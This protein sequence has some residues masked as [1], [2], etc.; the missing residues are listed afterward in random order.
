MKIKT[1]GCREIYGQI[2]RID[3][4]F[5]NLE[6]HLTDFAYEADFLYSNDFDNLD[7]AAEEAEKFDKILI[8][9][10]LDIPEHILGTLD[11]PK[12]KRDLSRADALTSISYTTQKQVKKYLD[13]NSEVIYNPVQKVFLIN[14]LYEKGKKLKFLN[15]S[16]R[17]DPN[18]RYNITAELMQKYFSPDQLVNVG[19]DPFYIGKFAG[20][21]DAKYLPAFYSHCDYALIG[22]RFGGIELQIPE[23]LICGKKIVVAPDCECAMEFAPEFAAEAPTADAFYK[24]IQEI[25]SNPE[26]YEKI[27]KEYQEIYKIQFNCTRI[28]ENIVEVF[29][30]IKENE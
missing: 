2:N 29:E 28:A 20:Q 1:Y 17:S 22:T 24:K 16:R 5:L 26:K 15:I 23:A 21:V 19:P 12:L 4:G 25:E 6:F 9:N 10:I 7:L 3:I 30:K 11:L 27:I 13:L 14:G 8:Q 18:K